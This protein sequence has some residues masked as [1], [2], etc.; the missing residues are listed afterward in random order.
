M[1]SAKFDILTFIRSQP[2][3]CCTT[4]KIHEKR[5]LG[6]SKETYKYLR[7]LRTDKYIS[8]AQHINASTVITITGHG[9]EAVEEHLRRNEPQ[10]LERLSEHT[11]D[12]P[13]RIKE[14][15]NTKDNLADK[16]WYQI[17]MLITAVVGAIATVATLF[18]SFI[19]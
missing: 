7:E 16:N 13:D 12:V 15:S 1:L 14:Q 4:F 9:E 17:A 11:H 18:I 10:L 8:C 3:K 2:N 6:K 5:G 19:E